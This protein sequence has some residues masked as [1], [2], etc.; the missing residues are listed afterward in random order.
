MTNALFRLTGASP[1]A[2]AIRVALRNAGIGVIEA[3][4]WDEAR[5]ALRDGEAA[6]VVA[7]AGAVAGLGTG[8]GADL[9]RDVARTVSH[10]LRTPLSA[11]AGWLHLIESGKL[12]AA[13]MERALGRLRG[14]IDDQVKTI[15]RYL[16]TPQ[17]GA[18]QK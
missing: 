15:E 16:G 10:E 3:D 4:S 14:N 9:P 18:A 5:D 8:G 2:E 11:M 13:G 12:D 17:G 7:D 1:A 6:L